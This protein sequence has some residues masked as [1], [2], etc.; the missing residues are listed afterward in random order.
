MFL[1]HFTPFV[2]GA[3]FLQLSVIMIDHFPPEPT[4]NSIGFD[5][6]CFLVQGGKETEYERDRSVGLCFEQAASVLQ[7]I[8]FFQILLPHKGYPT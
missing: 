3:E 4:L 7:M 2:G 1:G 5:S 8:F 6:P